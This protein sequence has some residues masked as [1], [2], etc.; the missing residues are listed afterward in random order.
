MACFLTF[1]PGN[2]IIRQGKQPG[3]TFDVLKRAVVE[4]STN[5]EQIRRSYRHAI[6]RVPRPDSH[7]LSDLLGMS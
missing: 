6:S 2:V 3:T 4:M 7:R 1:D 5:Q